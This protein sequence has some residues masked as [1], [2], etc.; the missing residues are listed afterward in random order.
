M[1]PKSVYHSKF[2]RSAGAFLLLVALLFPVS[3]SAR[4][5][6]TGMAGELTDQ[7]TVTLPE[8]SASFAARL[9]DGRYNSRISFKKDE[10]LEVMLPDGA[11]GLYIAWYAAPE[12]AQIEALSAAGTVLKTAPASTDLLNEYYALPDGCDSVRISGESAFA[13][14]EL[15]VFDADVPPDGLAVMSAPA[16]Q[17]KAMLVLAHTADEAFDFGSLLPYLGGSDAAIVFLSSESRQAQQQAIEAMYSLG[18]RTQPVFGAFPYYKTDLELKKLY[19]LIEKTDVTEWLIRTIRRYQP[20]TIITHA[21]DGEHDDGMSRLVAAH[22][23]IAAEQ[24][25]DESKEYVSERQYGVWQ[26]ASVYQHLETGSSPLYDTSAPLSGFGGMSALELAQACYERYTSLRL[27]HFS[28]SDTPYFVQTYPEGNG[29]S[30]QESGKSLYALLT[31]LSGPAGVPDAAV[32]PEPAATPEPEPAATPA[33]EQNVAAEPENAA[34]GADETRTIFFLGIGLA[35]LGAVVGVVSLTIR[36]KDGEQKSRTLRIVGIALGVL[37][38]VCGAVLTL[39]ANEPSEPATPTPLPTATP[40]AATPT[41]TASPEPTPTPDPLASHF[42]QEGDPAEVVVFDYDN[43]IF[44]YHSDTLGIEIRR[45]TRTDPPVVYYVAHIYERDEDSYR[46]G[47]GSGRLNGRDTADACVMAR[48]YRAVLGITGDNLLHSDYNRGLMIRDGRIFRSM[49]AVSAMA[50]TDDLSMRIY[51]AKDASMLNEIE[52]GTQNTYAFGPPLIMDGVL[53]EDVDSDRVGRINPRAGLGLVEPGH[54]VAI[55][56]DGRFPYFSHG[57]LLSN[58]AQ[59]FLDEGCVMAYNLDGGASATMVFMGEYI[60][61]RPENHYRS[62]PDQLLWGYSELVPTEDDP[63][64]YPRVVPQ[65][66]R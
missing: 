56:V 51:F 53:C 8:R 54:F 65:D 26:V 47:F 62:V 44:E 11:K 41:P 25:A 6:E 24:A 31:S 1:N 16:S 13:V 20:Q 32:T 57:V 64:V 4:A 42:R 23:L 12:A 55:V 46:S 50:L 7:C 48:R 19:G 28:V 63:Y 5:E 36:K 22:V 21:A 35:A 45:I 33:D 14:S 18:S 29:A 52:E 15:R 66:W 27:Y 59:M 2:L 34:S 43:G 30:E 39:R 10:M 60:N 58:F 61:R 40:E 3:G 9:T 37:L 49:T 17:V 38:L